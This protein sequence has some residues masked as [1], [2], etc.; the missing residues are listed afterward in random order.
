[1]FYSRNWI[2]GDEYAVS[3]VWVLLG[4]CDASSLGI[5]FPEPSDVGNQILGDERHLNKL[6]VLHLYP[7]EN[8]KHP[9]LYA[10][11]VQML[12]SM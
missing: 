5:Q 7:C 2:A 3:D 10:A 1:M 9:L 8:L 6:P 11:R 4:C 12:Y